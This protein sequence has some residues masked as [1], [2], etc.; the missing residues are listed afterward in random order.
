MNNRK[1]IFYM[2]GLFMTLLIASCATTY[3]NEKLLI[4]KWN[5]VHAE[6]YIKPVTNKTGSTQAPKQPVKNKTP[7]QSEPSQ[8]TGTES[9]ASNKL[10][11][12]IQ[13][14]LRSPFIV[15]ANKTA[16]KNFPGKTVTANWKMKKKGTRV[17][18]KN[19]ETSKQLKIDILSISDSTLEVIEY[20]DAGNLKVK[21]IK[22][23]K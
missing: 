5:P 18:A 10:T 15:Y 17:I 14:E 21:Y 8:S 22:D 1:L 16:E 19:P 11:H 9:R 23:V 7:E 2:L 12:M 3:P 20:S 13:T 6:E 4:G